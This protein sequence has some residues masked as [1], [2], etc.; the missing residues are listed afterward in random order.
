MF[1]PIDEKLQY[2]HALIFSFFLHEKVERLV[3]TGFLV[4]AFGPCTLYG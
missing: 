4:K 3:S 2:V 1:S